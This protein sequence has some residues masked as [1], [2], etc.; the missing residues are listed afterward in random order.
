MSNH[1]QYNTVQSELL[2]LRFTAHSPAPP[3]TRVQNLQGQ[4]MTKKVM[5]V[6]MRGRKLKTELSERQANLKV[7]NPSVASS[8]ISQK[9]ERFSLKRIELIEPL[10]TFQ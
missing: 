1:L 7:G 8:Q 2:G 5:A 3:S 4:G 9:T 6:R 10:G